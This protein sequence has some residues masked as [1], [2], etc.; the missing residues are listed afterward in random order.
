MTAF[1]DGRGRTRCAACR[2]LVYRS[3]SDAAGAAAAAA[4]RGKHLRPY[5]EPRCDSWHLSSQPARTGAEAR[6]GGGAGSG[7]CLILVLVP[8]LVLG[9]LLFSH[10]RGARVRGQR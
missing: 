8:A 7:C 9:A 10:Q 1:S 2:K 4:R 5:R 6:A 3:E